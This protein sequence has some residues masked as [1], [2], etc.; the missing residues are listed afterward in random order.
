MDQ[1][2]PV[3]APDNPAWAFAAIKIELFTSVIPF[4]FPPKGPRFSRTI[5]ILTRIL[6]LH[7]QTL[8]KKILKLRSFSFT[9]AKWFA[10]ME[11]GKRLPLLYPLDAPMYKQPKVALLVETARGYGRGFMRGIVNYSRLYGPWSF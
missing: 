5:S 2:S 6:V 1:S 9:E 10:I 4:S 3:K 11:I 7:K 8:R